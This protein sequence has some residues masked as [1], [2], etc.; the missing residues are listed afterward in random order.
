MR[1]IDIGKIK[2]WTGNIESHEDTVSAFQIQG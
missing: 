2:S 1:D